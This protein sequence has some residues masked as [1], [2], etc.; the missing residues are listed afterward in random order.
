M[1]LFGKTPPPAPSLEL[2]REESRAARPVIN[3]LVRIE[4]AEDGTVVLH[5]PRRQTPLI[6]TLCRFFKVPPHRRIALDK[7]G[8][9]VVDHC[10]GKNTV[11]DIIENFANAFRLNEREAD[12]S[13]TS[14]LRTLGQRYI[15]SFVIGE[16]A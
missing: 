10:D 11:H 12:V 5:V 7:L 1:P 9:F 4:H 6:R 13:V 16:L 14:F 15:I 2:T 8:T 3:R